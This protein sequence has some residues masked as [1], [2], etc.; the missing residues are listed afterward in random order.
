MS[1]KSTLTK[2]IAKTQDIKTVNPD[3]FPELICIAIAILVLMAL[4]LR[5]SSKR[6]WWKPSFGILFKPIRYINRNGYLQTHDNKLEHRSIATE[7]LGRE[8]RKN[9]VVHHING[10]KSDN[11]IEN[12]C[13]MTARNH[14][15]YHDWY[16]WI[17]KTYGKYPRRE[18]QLQRLTEK[19]NGI[20]LDD[21]ANNRTRKF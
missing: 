2:S 4:H 18:T 6:K 15:R 8:L 7:I 5:S 1:K 21:F 9:E 19:F 11:R 10:K 12:L 17:Y 3:S 20:L 16:D 14:D 13:V